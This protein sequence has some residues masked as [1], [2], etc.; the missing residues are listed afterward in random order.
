MIDTLTDHFHRLKLHQ[1]E[2]LL[3]GWEQL[4]AKQ[5]THLVEQLAGIDFAELDTLIQNKSTPQTVPSRDQLA[6]LPTEP[7]STISKHDITTGEQ[8]L[9][10]GEVAALLVAGGQGSRLGFPHPKGMFPIAPVSDATLFQLHAEQVLALR[11]RYNNPLSLLIMT[12]PTTHDETVQFFQQH[13]NFGLA[14][15]QIQFFQQG[16]MPAVDAATGKLLLEAP[17]QLALSPNG[18]GGTLTALA[19]TGLLAD[20]QSQGVK[21]IFYF[22]VDNPLVRIADPAFIG[23]HIALNSEVSSKVIFKTKPEEKVGVLAL[24]NGRCGIIEYSDMPQAMAEERDAEGN[25]SFRAGNP[26]IHIFSIEFLQRITTANNSLPY[27]VAHKKV[28]Y[29]DATSSQTIEPTTPNALKFERFIFDA[30]PLA[31][32]WLAVSIDREDEFAPVKNATG[33]DSPESSRLMQVERSAR[34]LEQAGVAVPRDEMGKSRFP[35]EI[36][37]GF[38]LDAD[39][40]VGKV[41]EVHSVTLLE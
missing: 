2:H 27:H 36:R 41:N 13:H 31:E 33:N 23:R 15:E 6:T 3:A 29:W 10:N 35:I 1:Q 40:C 25:L 24:V 18:H 8:A 7:R 30:L 20:L 11:K 17:G 16:T 34:W 28:P 37:P 4:D 38:A 19:E 39:D 22:Q 32:R 12:S 26:A 14:Q 21:Q 9:R 5:R